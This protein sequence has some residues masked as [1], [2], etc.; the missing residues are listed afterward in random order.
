VNLLKLWLNNGLE[1]GNHSYS[2]RSLNDTEIDFYKDDLIKCDNMLKEILSAYNKT[3]EFYRQPFLQFGKNKS[4]IMDFNKFLKVNKYRMAPV[5]I[6]NSDW[7]FA[8]AY[9]NAYLTK[10][11]LNMKNVAEEYIPYMITKFEYYRKQS[12][13][14]FGYEIKQILLIHASRLN[15]DYIG[16]LIEK[17]QK[18]G[19]KIITLQEAVKDRA[20]QHDDN[21]LGNAGI[22]WLHRWAKTEGKEKDFFDGEPTTPEFVLQLAGISEE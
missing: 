12:E 6:D 1:L 2:H 11:S 22:S 18:S 15:S 4:K 7:I 9:E 14:L 13:K 20:Y 21:Y 8:R 16:N 10:D 3:P 17:I 19:Y 5:T